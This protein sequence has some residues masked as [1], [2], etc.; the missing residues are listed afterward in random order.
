M[1]GADIQKQI[2]EYLSRSGYLAW[3]NHNIGIKGRTIGYLK[4]LPDIFALKN[5]RFFVIEV[6][7]KGDK[8]SIEQE[9]WI[10]KMTYYGAVAIVAKSLEDVINQGL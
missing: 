4:G 7:G 3:K 1:T 9:N 8:L 5:G 6:K 10:A 2:M